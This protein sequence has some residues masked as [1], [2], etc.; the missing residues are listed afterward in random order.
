MLPL[1]GLALN[2]GPS[3]IHKSMRALICSTLIL[4]LVAGCVSPSAEEKRKIE[5]LQAELEQAKK[6]LELQERERQLQLREDSLQA[7]E[8]LAVGSDTPAAVEEA[9]EPAPPAPK[10]KPTSVIVNAP[11]LFPGCAS[12]GSGDQQQS[13]SDNKLFEYIGNNLQ[14]PSVAKEKAIE[15]L[16]VVGF[17]ISTTGKVTDAQVMRDIGGGCGTEALRLV[18][19][20]PDWTPA[21]ENGKAVSFPTNLPVRFKL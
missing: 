21:R 8:D 6:E 3:Q 11:A 5:Q 12:G 4:W 7:V 14:Y 20:M 2:E 10:K 16:V 9:P 17:T 15:G 13:C 1:K 19:A 18:N